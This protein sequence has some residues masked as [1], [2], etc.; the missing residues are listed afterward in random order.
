ME[1]KPGKLY[2]AKVTLSQFKKDDVLM[3]LSQKI[4]WETGTHQ[5][6]LNT[7]IIE[8]TYDLFSKYAINNFLYFE[9]INKEDKNEQG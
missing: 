5:F 7:K 4:G 9:E 2:R 6:L 3:F 1:L 8:F